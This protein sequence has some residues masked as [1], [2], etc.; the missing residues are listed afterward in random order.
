[1]NKDSAAKATDFRR[2]LD[3]SKLIVELYSLFIIY[4]S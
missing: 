4:P 3:I 2:R 1:L